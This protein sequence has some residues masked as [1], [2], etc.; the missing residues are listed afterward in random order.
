M[1]RLYGK[2]ILVGR[3]L[4]PQNNEHQLHIT[5]LGTNKIGVIKCSVPETVSRLDPLAGTAHLSI[6]VDNQG[7]LKATNLKAQNYTYVNALPIK[8]KTI[9]QS[10]TLELSPRHF[11]IEVDKIIKTALSL[12]PA[13]GPVLAPG[14]GPKTEQPTF[15]IH[16]LRHCWDDYKNA[17]KQLQIDR[18]K[19]M[20]HQ[21]IPQAITMFG[22]VAG[23]VGAA[24]SEDLRLVSIIFAAVSLVFTIIFL[25]RDNTAQFNDLKEKIEKDFEISY[26]CPNPKCCKTLP[27]KDIDYILRQFDE[28]CPYCKC[29]YSDKH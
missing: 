22:T 26:I 8:S 21:R 3:S 18:A 10:D 9:S 29:H 15:N 27:S 17:I 4:K 6:E 7:N 16:H 20:R 25:M 2:T 13:V 14:S 1:K 23:G 11:K 12:I 5:I 24:I 28:K 19:A